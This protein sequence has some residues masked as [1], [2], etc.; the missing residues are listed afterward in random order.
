M[1]FK[2]SVK[3]E[4]RKMMAEEIMCDCELSKKREEQI[5]YQNYFTATVQIRYN[6]LI[7]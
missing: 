4:I 5:S 7:S 1:C 3:S 2:H 6:V